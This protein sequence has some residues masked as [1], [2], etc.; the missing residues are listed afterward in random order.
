MRQL[1][2]V[3]AWPADFTSG[4]KTGLLGTPDFVVIGVIFAPPGLGCFVSWGSQANFELFPEQGIGSKFFPKP[5]GL[6]S[7]GLDIW[8]VLEDLSHGLVM[9][10][11]SLRDNHSGSGEPGQIRS[12][13]N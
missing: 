9:L 13:G 8:S 3:F 12:A 6:A 10:W 11:F 2:R 1:R 7:W 4:D 5:E